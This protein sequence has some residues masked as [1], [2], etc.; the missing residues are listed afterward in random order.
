MS[1]LPDHEIRKLCQSMREEP[2]GDLLLGN[3]P[4]QKTRAVK[5]TPLIQPYDEA[6]LQPS[7][8]DVRLGNE[9]LA[10]ERDATLAIDMRDP[11]NITKKVVVSDGGY[12]LL[13][14]G[15]FVLGVTKEVLHVPDNLVARIEGK[16]SVGRLG[17][18]VHVTAGFIDPGFIGPITL[19][20]ACLHP[21]P[22]MLR[23][24]KLIAQFSFE[25]MESAAEKPYQGR[26]QGAKGVEASR[27]HPEGKQGAR[28]PDMSMPCIC[29]TGGYP[30][31]CPRHDNRI[32]E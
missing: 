16:S 11:A 20:M 7:S 28:K 29:G 21:L 12:F 18:M 23:P 14:P 27:Y 17:L 19:E 30:S 31:P 1:I 5:Q 25:R 24:G 4:R 32:G 22:I 26:Y 10:F 8:Y 3:P 2:Y 13:H 15:E 6:Q 9:F